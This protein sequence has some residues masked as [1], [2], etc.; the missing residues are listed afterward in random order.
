[1]CTFTNVAVDNLVEGLASSLNPLRVGYGDKV[2]PA[3]VPHTLD[4]KLGQ[5]ELYGE[6]IKLES[7]HK[8]MLKDIAGLRKS[9]ERTRIKLDAMH[10]EDE[11]DRKTISTRKRREKLQAEVTHRETMLEHVQRKLYAMKQQMLF[12]VVH[13]ADVVSPT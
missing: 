6:V 11:A 2:K 3:L 13:Q 8:S 5:H 12:D 1:V 9:L 4:A 7:Q 10:T